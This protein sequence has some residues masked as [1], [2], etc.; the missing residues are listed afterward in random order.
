ML[1]SLEIKDYALIDHTEIEFGRGLNIITGETGA[2]KSI[3]IDAMSL[4]LGERASVE[5][6][7]KGAQKA[8]VEGFFDVELNKKVRSLLE[9]NEIEFQPDLII[10]REISLKG[11]NRCFINDTPV[12]LTLIKQLGDLLVDLHGQHEHQSLLRIESHIGFLDEYSGNSK[13]IEEYQVF[14]KELNKKTSELKNLISKEESIKEKREI[15]AFQIKE[16]DSVSPSVGEDDTILNEL[17]ILENSEKLLELTEE[18][19]TKLY[20]AEP[21]VIDLLGETKHK[22]NQLSGIDKSFL[23]SEGE[24]DSALAIVKELADSLRSYK[25]KIDVD[26][27][28]TEYKRERLGA[29]NMLKKKYGG[30]IENIIEHRNKIGKDFELADNF[31]DAISKI[32]S[33]IKALQKSAGEAAEKISLSRKKSAAKIESEVIKSLNQLGISDSSFKVKISKTEADKDSVDFILFN[34]KKYSYSDTGFDEVEFYISTNIGEDVKPLTKVAS[35]GEV[36][37]IMLS[38][39]TIL[40]KSDKLPVLIFDEIDTGV[41]GRIAQKVGAAL[42]DLASFH[43]IIAITHLP[44][45]AGMANFHYSVEKKQIDDR[46]VSSIRQLDENE[47]INEVAKL[48]SG[49]VLTKESIESAKQLILNRQ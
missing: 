17:N 9:V 27:K 38:L 10:R 35:G 14:Y 26:P 36:S 23:E 32:Q 5:V 22:L 34:N 29:I 20:D 43:Q 4:L 37:R 41:S 31:S 42:R 45:I 25:S 2:G 8:F 11:S 39:K 44:Q 49:E 47:R 24:C 6:I 13:L 15:Y 16:I 33:E 46:T 19:Y 40:A 7:R 12:A 21:S 28:E 3:L 48:V 30:S 18:V 1:K